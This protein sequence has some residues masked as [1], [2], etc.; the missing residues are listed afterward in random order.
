MISGTNDSIWR[1]VT[2]ETLAGLKLQVIVSE[3]DIF[4]LFSSFLKIHY[5]RNYQIYLFAMQVWKYC[6]IMNPDLCQI[7]V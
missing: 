4:V 5:D 6:W 1:G 7:W 2:L 3:I